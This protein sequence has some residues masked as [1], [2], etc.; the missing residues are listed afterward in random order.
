MF[1]D[2]STRPSEMFTVWTPAAISV[3]D[4][5]TLK[6]RNRV[7]RYT[8]SRLVAYIVL[9]GQAQ[10]R[11]NRACGRR[12]RRMKAAEVS[13]EILDRYVESTCITDEKV[14]CGKVREVVV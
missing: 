5:Q 1:L 9:Q 2:T 10:S 13:A 12:D 7:A 3:N 6:W 14:M 4:I 8:D 11:E